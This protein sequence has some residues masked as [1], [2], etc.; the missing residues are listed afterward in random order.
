MFQ[1]HVRRAASR[2]GEC[3]PWQHSSQEVESKAG[4][5]LIGAESGSH[6]Y[7]EDEEIRGHQQNW[8]EDRPEYVGEGTTVAGQNIAAGHGAN[9][10]VIFRDGFQRAGE[11]L[12]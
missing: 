9:Q 4:G 10:T 1:D 2:F 11:K 12:G 6:H 8:V 7:A 3:E 5:T